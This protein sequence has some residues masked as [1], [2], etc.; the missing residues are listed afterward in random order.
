M[1]KFD[2]DLAREAAHRARLR[3][4]GCPD[5]HCHACR[6]DNIWCL[7][8]SRYR[9]ICANCLADRRHDPAREPEMRERFRRAGFPNPSCTVCGETK[10]WR[11][12]LDHIAGQKHDDSSSPLCRNCHMERSFMQTRE[13]EGSDEP[14]NVLEVIGRWLLGIAEWFELIKEK[15][16]LFGEFLIELARQGYGANLKFPGN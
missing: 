2:R 5:P 14:R 11:L 10:I 13:P 6:L 12:E 9:P 1:S 4:A 3:I 8:L 15:L 7:V 16:Y